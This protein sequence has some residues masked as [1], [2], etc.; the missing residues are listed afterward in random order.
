MFVIVLLHYTMNN[1]LHIVSLSTLILNSMDQQGKLWLPQNVATMNNCKTRASASNISH[2]SVGMKL[3][4][5]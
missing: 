4:T 2:K 3:I 1:V 5:Q